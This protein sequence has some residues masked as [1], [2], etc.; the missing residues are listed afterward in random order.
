M[1]SPHHL[2]L[3]CPSNSQL[4]RDS[5]RYLDLDFP[6]SPCRGPPYIGSH[7]ERSSSISASWCTSSR[8]RSGRSTI[9][10]VDFGRASLPQESVDQ[11]RSEVSIPPS[12]EAQLHEELEVSRV[13]LLRGGGARLTV[14]DYLRSDAYHCRAEFERAHHSQGRYVKAL[15]DVAALYPEIDLLPLY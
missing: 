3:R 14:A 2:G 12:S 4:A 8:W 7:R 1:G 9:D 13:M 10:R 15:A 11:L 6:H 5:R